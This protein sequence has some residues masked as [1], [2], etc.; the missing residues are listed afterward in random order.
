M[1]QSRTPAN[2]DAAQPPADTAA[3]DRVKPEHAQQPQPL[4]DDATD[5]SWAGEEDPGASLDS[6]VNPLPPAS[7]PS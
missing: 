2:D 4:P 5:R 7:R 1:D 6:V 3:D